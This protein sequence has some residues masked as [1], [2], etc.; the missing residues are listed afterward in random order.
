MVILKALVV[1]SLLHVPLAAQ[2]PS[3][4]FP[5]NDTLTYR[6]VTESR[7]ELRTGQ[8]PVVLTPRHDAT[9]ALTADRGDTVRAWY[10]Q[11]TLSSTSPQGEWRPSTSAALKLP[12]RLVIGP[13]GRVSALSVPS[14][15]AEIASRTDLT[16]QF[17][18]FFISLPLSEL[19]PSVAWADTLESTRPTNPGDTH[20]SRHVR[21]YR[22]L[23]DTVLAEGV[24]A[25]VIAFEQE[26]SVRSSSPM[27][28]AAATIHTRLEG[29][30]EGTAVFEPATSR[31]LSRVRRARLDGEQV[32][33]GEGREMSVPMSY[34]YSSSLSR[35]R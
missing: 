23:R 6:E 14:F 10:D 33:R 26:I 20:H 4:V 18:D 13:T 31:L 27:Q 1:L 15:P 32:L 30:E 5:L 7:I 2:R 24:T 8:G 12:F 11:L 34:E 17:E 35:L 29:R 9:I 3:Y 19:R 25:V 21:R 16:R 28:N 22:V